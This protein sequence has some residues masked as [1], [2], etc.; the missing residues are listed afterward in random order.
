M[1]SDRI[2]PPKRVNERDIAVLW[3][4]GAQVAPMPIPCERER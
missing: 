2:E 3:P 1:D 4:C